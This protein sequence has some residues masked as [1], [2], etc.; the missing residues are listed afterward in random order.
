MFIIGFLFLHDCVLASGGAQADRCSCP[1]LARD[2]FMTRWMRLLSRSSWSIEHPRHTPLQAVSAA[3]KQYLC[4][5]TDRLILSILAL[6]SFFPLDPRQSPDHE[7]LRFRD[8]PYSLSTGRIRNQVQD[9]PKSSDISSDPFGYLI[10]RSFLELSPR[11]GI[12]R[13]QPELVFAVKIC[14]EKL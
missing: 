6:E 5:G 12:S 3:A 9:G 10:G 14:S 2:G 7:I 4:D 13:F 1:S 11:A 8:R